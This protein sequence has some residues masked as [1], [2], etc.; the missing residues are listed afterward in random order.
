MNIK[1]INFPTIDSTNIYLKNHYLELD[2]FTIVRSDYQTKGRGRED[3]VWYSESGKNL[4]FSVL[5]KD[6]DLLNFGSLLSLV[7]A[8]SICESISEYSM[9]KLNPMIKWPNDVFIDGKK[10]CGIL[11]EGKLPEYLIIGIGLN[12]NQKIFS[13]EYR[14]S[15][16]SLSLSLSKD[17]DFDFLKEK[18]YSCLLSNLGSVITS[19]DKFLDYYQGHDYLKGKIIETTFN[20][21][22][23]KGLVK[24]IDQSFNLIVVDEKSNEH[25]ISSGEIMI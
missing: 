13:N 6:K 2:N 14:I 12:V 20:Q 22:M 19:K 8:Y 16:T 11:L 25:I 4:L 24:G 21:E 9:G 3:R 10:V 15:P 1:E 17:I 18:V 7:A 23:I 5:I